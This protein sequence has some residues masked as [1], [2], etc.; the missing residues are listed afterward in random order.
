MSQKVRDTMRCN[1]F[2]AY[3]DSAVTSPLF[4]PEPQPAF[5]RPAPINLAPKPRDVFFSKLHKRKTA[6]QCK[7]ACGSSP[8]RANLKVEAVLA[9]P[10]GRKKSTGTDQWQLFQS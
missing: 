5:I 4:G 10:A 1:D 7:C 9:Q 6:R 3:T 2:H 8:E